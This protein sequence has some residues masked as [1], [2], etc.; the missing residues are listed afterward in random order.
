[1]K[2]DLLFRLSNAD[3]IASKE[4]EVRDLLC[5]ELESVSSNVT[6]DRL[7]SILFHKKSTNEDALKLMFTAHIDEVGFLVRHI[8]DIGLVYLIAVGGV[9][10]KSKEMQMVRITTKENKKI[11]GILNVVRNQSGEVT[12]M[13]VDIGVDCVEEVVAQGIEIG[14][15]VCFASKCKSM[16]NEAVYVGKAMD[17]RC[18]CYV[19]AEAMKRLSKEEVKNELYFCG[20]S[21]EEVGARGA[22]TAVNQINPDIIFA[23]DVANNPAYIRDYTNHRLIGKGVLLVHYDK[24]LAPNPALLNFVKKTAKL[25]GIPYQSD[26]FSGGGTDAGSAHLTR[27]GKLAIVLGIPLRYCHSAWS[28]VHEEDLESCIALIVALVKTLTRE[29]YEKFIDFRGGIKNE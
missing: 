17:D 18:G 20:T 5:M 8:S 15:M 4:N 10:D 24:T 9:L 19:I 1:M 14:D 11:F 6:Y 27:N 13:Y 23:V 12:A 26:M 22:K 25:Y 2:S 21:S 28:I 29:T 16:C 7:G 3:A